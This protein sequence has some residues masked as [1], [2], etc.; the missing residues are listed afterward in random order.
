M[1]LRDLAAIVD[2]QLRLV[3]A[4]SDDVVRAWTAEL[5][6]LLREPV[7][8][9]RLVA[10]FRSVRQDRLAL[11]QANPSAFVGPL[12][13]DAVVAA[14]R[15]TDRGSAGCADCNGDTPGL[16]FTA[17]GARFCGCAAGHAKRERV[18]G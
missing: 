17:D 16:V 1:T 5:G 4:A 7:D 13:V 10:A 15:A 8:S 2:T 18:T 3:R 14:Y 9:I 6:D 11:T 12:S